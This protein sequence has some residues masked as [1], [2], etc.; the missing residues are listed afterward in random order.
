MLRIHAFA[1]ASLLALLGCSMAPRF[2]SA[3][4]MVTYDAQR[5]R[6]LY[7]TQC[8]ACHTAQAHWRDKR[9][10]Q[11]W[12][13]LLAEVARWEKTAGQNWSESDIDD[14]AAYL[15]GLFYKLPCPAAGCEGPRAAQE[16]KPRA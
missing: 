14:V 9:V 6:L 10:V 7:E 1:A 11:S 2:T 12:P 8:S 3:D 16:R 13:G 5:G 4:S 15:N